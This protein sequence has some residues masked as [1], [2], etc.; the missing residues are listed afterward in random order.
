MPNLI[1][2]GGHFAGNTLEAL[3]QEVLDHSA[4][5]FQFFMPMSNAYYPRVISAEEITQFNETLDGIIKVAHLPYLYN[6]ASPDKNIWNMSVRGL[7]SFIQQAQRWNLDFLVVHPGSYKEGTLEEGNARFMTALQKVA[8]ELE[9]GKKLKIL[10]ENTAG[11]GTTIGKLENL[12]FR[13]VDMNHPRFG[14]CLDTAH[15]YADGEDITV[16]PDLATFVGTYNP[17]VVHFNNPDAKVKLGS[18]LDRH[19]VGINGAGVW[20]TEQIQRVFNALSNKVLIVE[21]SHD[22]MADFKTIRSWCKQ[23]AEPQP[24]AA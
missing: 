17:D 8:E 23:L 1:R 24:T 16:I 5:A 12:T 9:D 21:G 19:E 3:A 7:R 11:G 10:W 18:H 2:F 22:F 14:L 15:L 20:K 13:L 6:F 4:G